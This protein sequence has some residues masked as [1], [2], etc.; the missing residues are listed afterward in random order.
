M[1][2]EALLFESSLITS[3]AQSENFHAPASD[4][5]TSRQQPQIPKNYSTSN[6]LS[7]H[8]ATKLTVPPAKH[9]YSFDLDAGLRD[10][11]SLTQYVSCTLS[12]CMNLA[13]VK[14]RVC[15]ANVH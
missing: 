13:D 7:L 10:D 14:L 2:Y 5:A 1:W 8:A 9:R 3:I 12:Y 11:P 15:R 6:L 4:H